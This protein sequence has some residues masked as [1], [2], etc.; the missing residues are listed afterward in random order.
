MKFKNKTKLKKE[1]SPEGKQA[2]SVLHNAGKP[3]DEFVEWTALDAFR[4]RK[5][6]DIPGEGLKITVVEFQ[7]KEIK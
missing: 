3:I 7:I 1:L 4:M 6:E 2:I 5:A